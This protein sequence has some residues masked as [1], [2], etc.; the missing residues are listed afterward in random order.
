MGRHLAAAALG[1]LFSLLATPVRAYYFYTY[2][3]WASCT[4]SRDGNVVSSVCNACT[5]LS[6]AAGS[7]MVGGP[8]GS[9][10]QR[11]AS[12]NCLGTSSEVQVSSPCT[13]FFGMYAR[14][15]AAEAPCPSPAA[16]PFP[17]PTP[18]P[19]PSHAPGG[20]GSAPGDSSSNGFYTFLL[21]PAV[22][23]LIGVR[24]FCCPLDRRV[25]GLPVRSRRHRHDLRFTVSADGWGDC[26]ASI[27]NNA[28][29]SSGNSSAY[30]SSQ[31]P[32][33]TCVRCPPS[34]VEAAPTPH[35][36]LITPSPSSSTR[37]VQGPALRRVRAA[38]A[39]V[40][41]LQRVQLR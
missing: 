15:L 26:L 22:I 18:F 9:R 30:A 34:A 20:S 8:L 11:W 40:V 12:V 39:A 41:H 3:D 33:F 5:N 10:V 35:A 2:P 36:S 16:G 19:A 4:Q 14:L 28:S 32:Q 31:Q 1:L 17:S 27:N 13:P 37:Q 7:I 6:P 25:T 23:A 29:N 21:I 24:C 38:D